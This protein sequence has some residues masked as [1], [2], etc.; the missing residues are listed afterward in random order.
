ME[1]RESIIYRRTESE[2][3]KHTMASPVGVTEI[4]FRQPDESIS[5]Y[6]AENLQSTVANNRSFKDYMRVA[7]S[8]IF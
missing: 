4:I 3:H 1:F 2:N 5:S 8:Q 6:F 7:I